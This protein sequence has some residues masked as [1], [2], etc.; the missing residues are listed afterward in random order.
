MCPFL[1]EII[2]IIEISE[3]LNQCEINVSL[4]EINVF[5]Q[6]E[7]YNISSISHLYRINFLILI[8]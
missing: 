2:E 1:I 5:A 4:V 3:V 8:Y 7:T 6:S